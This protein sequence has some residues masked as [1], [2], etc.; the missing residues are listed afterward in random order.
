MST[1]SPL[2]RFLTTPK[3]SSNLKLGDHIPTY[4]GKTG[5]AANAGK[6]KNDASQIF[7]EAIALT[8]QSHYN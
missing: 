6:T 4:W 5:N 8:T 7:A 3:R 1:G 2:H